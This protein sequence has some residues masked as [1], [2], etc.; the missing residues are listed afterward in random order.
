MKNL[1]FADCLDVL[2]MFNKQFSEGFINLIYIDPP[3]NSNRDYK[4]SQKIAFSDIW[5]N[6]S[7][8]K[9]LEKLFNIENEGKDLY[10]FLKSLEILRTQHN[11]I[12]YLTEMSIRI[13]YM[14]YILKDSG[15]FYLHCDPTMS[16]YLKIICDLIFGK[17]NFR[18]EIIWHYRR[19]TNVS[20]DFQRMHD[21]ILRYSKSENFTFH[22]HFEITPHIEKVY[23]RGWDRNVAKN[24]KQ[25][26]IY[27]QEKAKK[28]IEKKN[29]DK[30]IFC[31]QKNGVNIS[32]VW[33]INYLS[34]NSNERLGYPTQKPEALLER[35][36]KTSTNEGDIVADFFCGCGTTIVAAEKLN[37]NWIATDKS[38][39]AIKIIK[40]RLNNLNVNFQFL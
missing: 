17:N 31:E 29:Y 4:I 13:L 38:D 24:I 28:Q 37:R 5:K 6:I 36:I 14:K 1:Y 34:A 22:Q 26:I 32:D 18:N 3:Y 30:L 7:Y 40:Q 25:L 11:I 39:E 20:K 23:K 33:Q 16:H 12:S 9:T 8:Q 21:V 2:Q 19:W 15:S 10:N 35:I 27:D